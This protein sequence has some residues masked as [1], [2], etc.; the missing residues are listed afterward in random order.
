MSTSARKARKRAGVSFVKDQKV[1]SLSKREMAEVR[2]FGLDRPEPLTRP[3]GL[4]G[5]ELNAPVH[6]D[7][8]GMTFGMRLLVSAAVVAVL[9]GLLLVAA[10]VFGLVL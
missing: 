5:R 4:K 8:E 3:A 6:D 10:V 2:R 1:P 7:V 9:F